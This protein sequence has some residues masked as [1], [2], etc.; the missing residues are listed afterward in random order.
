[1]DQGRSDSVCYLREED[2]AANKKQFSQCKERDSRHG[3]ESSC[4][5]RGKSSLRTQ[6]KK[7]R[8]NDPQKSLAQKKN[9]VAQKTSCLRAREQAVED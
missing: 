1:M 8:E 9:H 3:Q 2:D 5:S 7:K 6:F 4:C